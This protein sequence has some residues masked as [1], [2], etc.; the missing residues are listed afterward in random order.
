M[1]L[2]SA[3]LINVGTLSPEWTDGMR[4]AASAANDQGK[5]WVLDPVG[6]GATSFR[7]QV[8]APP[9]L[10]ERIVLAARQGA[11]PSYDD[12]LIHSN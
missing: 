11:R 9:C 1:K 7:T 10:Y 6:A 8:R 12:H 5:P 2:A 4:A 3:V